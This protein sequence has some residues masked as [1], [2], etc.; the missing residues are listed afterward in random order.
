[1]DNIINKFAFNSFADVIF[2]LDWL[3]VW[4][5]DEHD[6]GPKEQSLPIQVNLGLHTGFIHIYDDFL[7]MVRHDPRDYI[8]TRANWSVSNSVGV[9]LGNW[10][11]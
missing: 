4:E 10:K 5:V 1:M 3:D 8:R 7:I 11:L 9:E 6:A 2:V